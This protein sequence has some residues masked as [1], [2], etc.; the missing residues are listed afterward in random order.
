MKMMLIKR[1]KRN[2]RGRREGKKVEKEKKEG[3]K[4][5]R[6]AE[7]GRE[8]GREEEGKRILG[9]PKSLSFFHYIIWQNPEEFLANPIL[10]NY[11]MCCREERWG[12]PFRNLVA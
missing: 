8:E 9:W 4:E 12:F 3:R 6:K 10:L 11:I 1:K 2:E 7:R 5:E